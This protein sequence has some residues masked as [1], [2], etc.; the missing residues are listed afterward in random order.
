MNHGVGCVGCCA[1]GGGLAIRC[2]L[3]CVMC[4]FLV[5]KSHLIEIRYLYLLT[6]SSGGSLAHHAYVRHVLV[7]QMQYSHSM[8]SPLMCVCV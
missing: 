6:A 1:C 2:L 7:L 4:A 3:A 8:L 5:F